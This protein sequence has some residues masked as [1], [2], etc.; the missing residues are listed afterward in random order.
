MKANGLVDDDQAKSLANDIITV[1]NLKTLIASEL[2]T[3]LEKGNL[4]PGTSD[5]DRLVR[6]ERYLRGEPESR[7]EQNVS[8]EWLDEEGP[9]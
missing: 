7:T 5:Y 9:A 2:K 1:S 4:Q 3:L 6:L 8:F